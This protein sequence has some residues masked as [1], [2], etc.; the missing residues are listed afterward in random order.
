MSYKY[1]KHDPWNQQPGNIG[2]QHSNIL[3]NIINNRDMNQ[4]QSSQSLNQ[5]LAHRALRVTQCQAWTCGSGRKEWD[6][7]TL[8]HSAGEEEE[9]GNPPTCSLAAFKP[10]TPEMDGEWA[11]KDSA[12]HC[13]CA[14]A[15]AL[16]SDALRAAPFAQLTIGSISKVSQPHQGRVGV[17]IKNTLCLHWQGMVPAALGGAKCH[18]PPTST[19]IWLNLSSHDIHG[20]GPLKSVLRIGRGCR[21]FFRL[22]STGPNHSKF[23]NAIMMR[24]SCSV[25]VFMWNILFNYFLWKSHSLGPSTYCWG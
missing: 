15:A 4:A 12:T 6:L 25:D 19:L 11:S 21:F 17:E 10:H 23:S 20:L 24:L 3:S 7:S 5:I 9:E 16:V 1:C 22:V 2:Q 18:L 13:E 8:D 14:A